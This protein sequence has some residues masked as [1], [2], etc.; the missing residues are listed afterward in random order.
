MKQSKKKYN[1]IK[2]ACKISRDNELKTK[3][4]NMDDS[5]KIKAIR[6]IVEGTELKT[7]TIALDVLSDIIHIVYGI[8]KEKDLFP[9][10]NN[11]I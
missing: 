4:C 11:S 8:D 1:S 5:Q 10:N 3:S 6:T 9:H 7:A 2:A